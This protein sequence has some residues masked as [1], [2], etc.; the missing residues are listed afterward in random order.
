MPR[1]HG[2][3]KTLRFNLLVPD[4][5]NRQM[6]CSTDL[7]RQVVSY[8]L[9]I[10]QDHQELIGHSQWLKMAETLTHRTKSNLQPTYPFDEEYPNLPSGIRRAAISEACGLAEAWKSSYDKWLTKKQKTEEKNVKRITKGKKPVVIKEHPPQYPV[11]NNSW[12]SYYNTEFKWLDKH[13]I[14]L[15]LYTGS[16]YSYRKVALFQ[17]LTVPEG[18]ATGSP[19]LIHK[20]TGWELH[21]PLVLVKKSGLRKIKYI[22]NDPAARICTVDLGMNRHAAITI[23]DT[24]GRV[25]ATKFISGAQDNH[26]R[27]RYLEKIVQL[28][29]KTMIIP[30]GER[31]AKDLWDKVSN[32]NNNIAHKVSRQIV[33]FAL[34][35]GAKIIVFEY[36]DNLRPEKGTKSHW[37]N[38]RF[39]YWVKGRV[40]RHTQY[41]GLHAGIVTSRVSPQDT[42]ARCPYCGYL[43]IER[44]TPGK[45]KGVDLARCANCGVH[46]INADFIGALGIGRNFRLKHLSHAG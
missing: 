42:S 26:L 38:R 25:Y 32:F 11:E 36:L 28:Q 8:Y 21:V 45:E 31:F 22:V 20:P 41:K 23:Q 44:Y 37:L 34:V 3:T 30:E 14:L 40:F 13:H 7:Y 1:L 29:K 43:A 15:K 6:Y 9:Q 18:Y 17:P 4:S 35:H 27:K 2:F 46:D 39:G 5:I 19:S 16:S 33:D 12:V 10:F 24:K